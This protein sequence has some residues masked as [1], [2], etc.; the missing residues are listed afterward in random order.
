MNKRVYVIAE[1]GVN[2]NGSLE[3]AKRLIDEAAN[4]GADAVKFQTFKAERLVSRY[5]EKA[6]YQKKLTGEQESQFDMIRKLELSKDDHGQLIRHCRERGI[7]FLSTPF[8]DVSLE[9]LVRQYGLRKIK[10]SSGDLTNLP[11]LLKAASM[12]CQ[13]ILSTG[14]ATLGEIEAALGALAFGYLRPGERP[15]L[16]AFLRAYSLPEGQ[17]LL[18]QNVTLLH[19]TTEYPTPYQDV[20]LNKM[21]TLSRA[22]ELPVGYSDHTLGTEVPVAAVALG[23]CVIEKHFTLD[24]NMEGPDHQA[25][26]EPQELAAMIEQIR[27]LELALGSGRKCPAAS[28]LKNM[29]PVRKSIVAARDIWKGETFDET[30]LT[31]KRPGN[32]LPPSL[33][34]DMLGRT[35]RRAYQKDELI[36][37]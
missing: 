20:H 19:C 11:L 33:Y 5:A 12:D 3:L 16:Q 28:E 27:H 13:V 22:F 37:W 4:A 8:D 32:G 24:K 23:A 6:D 35:A 10:I 7:E 34:W 29:T 26:L 30:N 1:A 25:S 18:K 17:E 21:V 9:L 36:E 15:S 2:H 31:I 14:M